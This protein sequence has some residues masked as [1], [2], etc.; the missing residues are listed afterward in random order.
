M[1]APVKNEYLDQVVASQQRVEAEL[2]ARAVAGG[3]TRG[4]P[5]G[6]LGVRITGLWRFKTVVVPPNVYV[7]HT[8]YT[9]VDVLWYHAL[10][11]VQVMVNT[12]RF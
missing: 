10:Q 8:R 5:G 1:D 11:Q 4:L 12:G 7:V 3:A 2:K 6:S 9:P